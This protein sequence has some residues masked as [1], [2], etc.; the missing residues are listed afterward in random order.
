MRIG[1]K[2]INFL[3]CILLKIAVEYGYA[4][5]VGVVF[6]YTGIDIVFDIKKYIFSWV[7]AVF[8]FWF[9]CFQIEENYLWIINMLFMILSYIPTISL[10][11][12]TDADIDYIFAT[13]IFLVC[14]LLECRLFQALIHIKV[15]EYD[16]RDIYSYICN[17]LRIIRL[18]IVIAF[19]FSLIFSQIY[20]NGRLLLSFEDS[21]N[22]RLAL[23]EVAIPI[24]PRYLFMILGSSV[25]PLLCTICLYINKRIE[26]IVCLLSSFLLYTVNGMKTWVMM[27]LV[28]FGLFILCR[29]TNRLTVVVRWVLL[30]ISALWG[31]GILEYKIV[32]T[33]FLLAYLHRIQT[34]LS[35]LH[36]YYYDFFKSHQFLFLRDSVGRH[37]SMSPY[38]K[39]V[40]RLIGNIYYSSQTM[41]CTNGMFSDFYANFGYA[42]FIIYPILIFSCFYIL[43]KVLGKMGDF[44]TISTTFILVLVLFD[45]TFFTWII[46]GGYLAAVIILK[47][48]RKIY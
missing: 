13:L 43:Y 6:A 14:M 17:H 16:E 35:E 34:L 47:L 48:V 11:G 25:L 23:R 24:L 44:I 2:S 46:T 27:Y 45:N 1:N 7:V 40:S 12:I 28:I 21:L 32:G 5:G 20:A 30:G 9:S 22:A 29:Y 19:I 8:I 26:V 42:G 10:W 31:T 18:S 33:H 36:Y 38:S 3:Y 15:L 37:I 39:P 4:K 41:N